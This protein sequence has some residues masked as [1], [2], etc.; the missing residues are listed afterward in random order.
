MQIR[1]P[2]ETPSVPAS[3]PFCLGENF[4]VIYEPPAWSEQQEVSS[5]TWL[6]RNYGFPLKAGTGQVAGC[7]EPNQS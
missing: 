1:R 2:P 5:M 6:C 3:C 7:G 4:G